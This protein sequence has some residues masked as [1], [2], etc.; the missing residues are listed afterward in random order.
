MYESTALRGVT[1]KVFA[2]NVN[3]HREVSF[4]V[5]LFVNS[6]QVGF[7]CYTLSVYEEVKRKAF[8]LVNRLGI[9]SDGTETIVVPN[10]DISTLF[11][12]QDVWGVAFADWAK[13]I[14][15]EL[16]KLIER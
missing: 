7:G 10:Q 5:E 12:E 9:G 4:E 14:E 11:P 2:Q 15:D 3:E 13:A 16:I 6:E 1:Y 8:Y